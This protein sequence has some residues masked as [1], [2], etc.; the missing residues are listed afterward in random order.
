MTWSAHSKARGRP[1]HSTVGMR[2]LIRTL[3]SQNL[4]KISLGI[5]GQSPTF[6]VERRTLSLALTQTQLSQSRSLFKLSERRESTKD[7]KEVNVRRCSQQILCTAE[8][9]PLRCAVNVI[10]NRVVGF[11][12]QCCILNLPSIP[13]P[14]RPRSLLSWSFSQWALRWSRV[15]WS[16]A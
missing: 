5:N 7:G 1:L 13:S 10:S 15:I 4:S 16:E 8:R 14:F 12:E 6:L 2:P 11:I 9:S 3:C